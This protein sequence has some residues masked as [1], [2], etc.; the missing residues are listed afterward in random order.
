LPASPFHDELV[1]HA[2]VI[3]GHE[4]VLGMLGDAG[5][6]RRATDAVAEPFGS[7]GITK[8]AGPSLT[9]PSVSARRPS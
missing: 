3:D 9:R 1:A 8:V 2:V 5:I 7:S 4:D 6:M